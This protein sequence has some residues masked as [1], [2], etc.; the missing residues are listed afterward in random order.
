MG[1][2]VD[3]SPMPLDQCPMAKT[4]REGRAVHG[5]RIIVE[6]PDGTRRQVFPHPEPVRN[7]HGALVGAVNT[8]VDVTVE[9]ANFK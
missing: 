6:R 1:F 4:L 8:L 5:E 3:G 7:S 2:Q 9:D